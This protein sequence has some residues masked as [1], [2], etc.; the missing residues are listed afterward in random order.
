MFSCVR[1]GSWESRCGGRP[2][3]QFHMKMLTVWL[4]VSFVMDLLWDTKEA[5]TAWTW[6]QNV[7]GLVCLLKRRAE[8]T[9]LS[10]FF[11]FFFFVF[12]SC[13]DC[14]AE[15]PTSWG[16]PGQDWPGWYQPYTKAETG[17][18]C[19]G[20]LMADQTNLLTRAV[21]PAG[22]FSSP[23]LVQHLGSNSPRCP[24]SR[25]DWLHINKTE[26]KAVSLEKAGTCLLLLP[27]QLLQ[28]T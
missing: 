20:A 3:N 26:G 6:K 12:C 9:P 11:F 27:G 10:F 4:S 23:L 24:V 22:H 15:I 19:L 16:S 18:N 7:N 17:G 25:A 13:P 1:W 8:I 21:L 5:F 14:F 28:N 2:G